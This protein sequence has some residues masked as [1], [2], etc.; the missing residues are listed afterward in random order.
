MRGGG[1]RAAIQLERYDPPA[2]SPRQDW[3][4]KLALL[5]KL[6]VARLV[7]AIVDQVVQ[8]L[9]GLHQVQ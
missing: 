3:P 6:P 4:H 8:L 1:A 2:T 7:R 5:K 9:P